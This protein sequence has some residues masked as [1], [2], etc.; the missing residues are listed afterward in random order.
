[1]NRR[2]SSNIWVANSRVGAIIR[3]KGSALYLRAPGGGRGAASFLAFPNNLDKTGIRNA[4]VL[5][6]PIK[7]KIKLN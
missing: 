4:A 7:N 1:M 3:T 2:H 6:E 5:P